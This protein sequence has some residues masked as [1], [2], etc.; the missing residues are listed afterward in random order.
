MSCLSETVVRD[1]TDDHGHDAAA[2][3]HWRFRPLQQGKNRTPY[4][5]RDFPPADLNQ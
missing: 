2:F 5:L 4:T 3:P 1:F